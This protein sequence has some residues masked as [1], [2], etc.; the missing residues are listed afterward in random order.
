MKAVINLDGTETVVNVEFNHEVDS[1]Y[2]HVQLYRENDDLQDCLKFRCKVT[3]INDNF[4][5]TANDIEEFLNK[6]FNSIFK[7]N[8]ETNKF[9][10]YSD[11]DGN[12]FKSQKNSNN[13]TLVY[14]GNLNT[15]MLLN[16]MYRIQKDYYTYLP[17]Y[18]EV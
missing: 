9:E 10:Y 11:K 2:A 4:V 13:G 15:G 8:I 1:T 5:F 7:D 17:D 16:Y 14:I 3:L 18:T 6:P 12:I